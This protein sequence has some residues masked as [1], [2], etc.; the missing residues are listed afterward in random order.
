MVQVAEVVRAYPGW[1]LTI[2][3]VLKNVQR[4]IFIRHVS[5]Q[6]VVEVGLVGTDLQYLQ[7]GYRNILR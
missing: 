6:E 1:K 4:S 7:S 3:N 2:L 5:S